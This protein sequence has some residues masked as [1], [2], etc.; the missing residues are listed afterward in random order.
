MPRYAVM[1]PPPSPTHVRCAIGVCD[2]GIFAVPGAIFFFLTMFRQQSQYDS[3]LTLTIKPTLTLTITLTLTRSPNH[4]H[5]PNHITNSNPNPKPNPNLTITL[6]LT[7]TLEPNLNRLS[8]WDC[9]RRPGHHPAL[10]CLII[11]CMCEI[12][13]RKVTNNNIRTCHYIQLSVWHMPPSLP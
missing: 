7:K 11:V 5:N 6:T 4:N 12:L 2:Y 8:Y 3:R 13:A 9:C 1:P 10:V